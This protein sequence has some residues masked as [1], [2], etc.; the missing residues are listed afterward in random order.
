MIEL[1]VHRFNMTSTYSIKV[2]ARLRP[3]NDDE[4][5][6]LPVVHASSLDKQVTTLK[7]YGKAQQRTTFNFDTVFSPSA[8]QEEVF[9][10]TLKPVIKDVLFGYE[11][12]VFAYGQTG[13][14]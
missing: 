4:S 10:S 12:T 14:K 3:L 9:D 11:S 7:G 6:T 13:K 8:T 2:A 1:I 5:K